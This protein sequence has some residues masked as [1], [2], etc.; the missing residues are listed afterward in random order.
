MTPGFINKQICLSAAAL[1]AVIALFYF[2]DL[3]LAISAKLYD[4]LTH[5]WPIRIDEPIK[6]LLL[7]DGFK[8]AFI[9]GCSCALIACA[10]L[11]KSAFVQARK[12]R[13]IVF[14]FSVA[15]VPSLVGALKNLTEVPCPCEIVNFGRIYPDIKA[16]DAYSADFTPPNKAKCWPA[17][18]ASMGFSLM[19]LYFVCRSTRTRK[20]SLATAIAIG[21]ITDGYKMLLGDHF[22]SHTLVTMIL[23]WLV[24]LLIA[25]LSRYASS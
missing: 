25:K 21:W 2:S 20:I 24:I 9:C 17:G 19:S 7:Y 12:K 13:L 3:D 1:I 23:A 16:F 4:P 6:R 15:F 22:F 10:I 11:Y 18:H 5:S 8:R 14:F